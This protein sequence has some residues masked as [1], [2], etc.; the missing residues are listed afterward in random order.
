MPGTHEGK[1]LV[2][3]DLT[4]R[5]EA[6]DSKPHAQKLVDADGANLVLLE[7][8]AGQI[9]KEHHS[10]HP[11][12]VQAIKGRVEFRVKGET[13]TLVPGSPIHLTAHLLHELEAVEDSTIMVTMLTGE[14]HPEP[15]IN[16]ETTV[17]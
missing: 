11:I 8:K 6:F 13:I 14:S 10:V 16:T 4:Q 15:K 5:L 3:G 2:F 17:F 12:V 9:W 1:V 7:F